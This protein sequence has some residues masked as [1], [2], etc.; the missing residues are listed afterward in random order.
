MVDSGLVQIETRRVMGKIISKVGTLLAGMASFTLVFAAPVSAATT[1]VQQGDAGW[2]TASTNAGASVGIEEDITTPLGNSSLHITTDGTAAAKGQYLTTNHALTQL[3]DVDSLGYWTKQNANHTGFEAGLPS[4]QLEIDANGNTSDAIGYTTMVFEPYNNYGN[5]AVVSETWQQW[6]IDGDSGTFWSSRN[7]AELTGG[8][9]GLTAGGGG[10]PFYTLDQLQAK[11]PDAVVLRVGVNVGGNN[12]N[13]DTSVDGVSFNDTLY[14]FETVTLAVPQN[15]DECKKGGWESFSAPV[16]F[17]NQGQC[18]SFVETMNKRTTTQQFTLS[19][20]DIDGTDIALED[21]KWYQLS[22]SGTWTNRA[23][24][25]V[26]A[27]CTS[28]NG[29]AWMNAVDGGYS[30]DLLDVQ[31]NE[32]F[33]NWGNCSDTNTYT[34]WVQG[35]SDDLNLRIFDGDTATNTQNPGWFGDNVGDLNVTL[36][37]YKQ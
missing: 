22:V 10:A 3:D 23:G 25:V 6:S 19:S 2:S 18:V 28:Y 30:S 13:Y 33:V 16:S 7:V 26:D 14:D 12:P 37:S 34:K 20:T 35:D 17:K 15:K 36:T 24:E 1:V 8:Q 4:F 11:Y 29:G 5:A 27:E 32:Q 9:G 21:S 31:V